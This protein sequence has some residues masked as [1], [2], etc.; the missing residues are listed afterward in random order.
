MTVTRNELWAVFLQECRRMEGKC[1]VCLALPPSPQLHQVLPP[2]ETHFPRRRGLLASPPPP[3]RAPKAAAS[4][5]VACQGL[6]F[7]HSGSPCVSLVRG[8]KRFG[9]HTESGSDSECSLAPAVDWPLKLAGKSP[10]PRAFAGSSAPLHLISFQLQI[11]PPPADL[12][13]FSFPYPCLP[14]AT[15]L[16]FWVA[17]DC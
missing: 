7:L 4:S 1:S 5:T 12:K 6:G 15:C 10:C 2:P 8:T 3:P 13:F 17:L 11:K 16:W 14:E 9:K